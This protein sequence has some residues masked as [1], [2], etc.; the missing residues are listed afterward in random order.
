MHSKSGIMNLRYNKI[1]HMKMTLM[2]LVVV[3]MVTIR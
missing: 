3:V 1:P 2:V